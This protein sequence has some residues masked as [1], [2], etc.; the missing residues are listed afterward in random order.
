M[1]K[2]GRHFIQDKKQQDKRRLTIFAVTCPV[3][4]SS[5]Q[6]HAF[7][8]RYLGARWVEHSHVNHRTQTRLIIFLEIMG[9]VGQVGHFL[10]TCEMKPIQVTYL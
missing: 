3:T 6:P 7:P 5:P 10:F 9:W 1:G 4:A 2:E 8:S